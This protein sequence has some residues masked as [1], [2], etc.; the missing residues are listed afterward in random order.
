L[1]ERLK[2]LFYPQTLQKSPNS[3]SIERQS[4]KKAK[5]KHKK[6]KGRKDLKVSGI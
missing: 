6:E 3:S 5:K 2:K 1:K 4:I